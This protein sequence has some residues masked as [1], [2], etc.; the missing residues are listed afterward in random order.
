VQWK[1]EVTSEPWI[2]TVPPDENDK[3]VFYAEAIGG[4]PKAYDAWELRAEFLRLRPE[5]DGPKL[6]LEFLDKVGMFD[7]PEPEDADENP[8][9]LGGG[10]SVK[11]EGIRLDFRSQPRRDYWH[12]W[13]MQ[14]IFAEE[15]RSRTSRQ[16]D[17]YEL[18][19][20][21]RRG[22]RGSYAEIAATSFMQA[23]ITTIKIDHLRGAKFQKC[24]R[25]DCG[26]I[27][28]VLGNR[29]RKYCRWYCGHLES[30]RRQRRTKKAGG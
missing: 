27:F 16:F 29:S 19:L 20:R 12:F 17:A 2:N 15:M 4:A 24:G 8:H 3:L 26:T 22:R 5:A 11:F 7:K 28:P 14:R 21:F 30:V 18:P 25:L 6:L 9:I 1:C 10:Y 13:E 23:V